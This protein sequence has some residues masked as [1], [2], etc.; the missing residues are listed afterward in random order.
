M[1][2]SK[3]GRHY[4][5]SK[6]LKRAGYKPTVFCANT[7]HNGKK[8]I[9]IIEKKYT[10]KNDEHSRFVF[11]KSSEY[12]GNGLKRVRN[13]ISFSC[14]LKKVYKK[15][16][17]E[18]NETPDIILASSVHPLTCVIGIKIAKKLNIP[19][20]VEIRDL[21]PESIVEYSRRLTKKNILVKLMYIGEKWIYKNADKIIFTRPKDRQYI[22][23]R[24]WEKDIPDAKVYYINNGIDL[25]EFYKNK[26]EYKLIDDDLENKEKINIVYV[27]SIRQVNNLGL[28]LDIAKMVDDNRIQFLIWGDGNQ[29]EILEERIRVENINNVIMKGR[30]E[31]QYIPYIVS[32]ADINALHNQ[33]TNILRF[34]ISWNKL[35]DYY[36]AGKPILAT[37]NI[38]YT[39][40][41]DSVGKI[42]EIQDAITI[43]R[44]IE[45]IID[46]Y[47]EISRQA[48]VHFVK[49]AKE[50]DF[51]NLTNKL[52]SI[53]EN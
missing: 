14:N 6:F 31:K 42:V 27:G 5:F 30:V 32:A 15:Y 9:E 41:N 22:Y 24:G 50:Y 25:E 10:V 29:K 11:V 8:S 33:P 45:H 26:N 39:E 20:I 12:A 3:A 47:D 7:F 35:F 23:E 53:I 1:F 19:C 46:N 36:A 44:G 49:V 21:W 40:I 34:G 51:T 16:S 13:M 2:D 43:K 38:P 17:V 37:L 52:I 28:L 18:N 48:E 4:S